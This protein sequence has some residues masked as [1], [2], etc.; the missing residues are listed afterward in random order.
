[1]LTNSAKREIIMLQLLNFLQQV[2]NTVL[3]L[4]FR[5][6][7]LFH[8]GKFKEMIPISFV[9]FLIKIAVDNPVR[10]MCAFI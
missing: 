8:Y 7:P 9:S 4:L 6:S 3:S 10:I 1:M 5:T 2:L